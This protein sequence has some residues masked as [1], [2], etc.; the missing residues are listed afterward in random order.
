MAGMKQLPKLAEA[1]ALFFRQTPEQR[2]ATAQ[3]RAALPVDQ[4]GLGLPADNT[5]AQ[6][7]DVMFPETVYRGMQNPRLDNPNEVRNLDP[8]YNPE[9]NPVVVADNKPDR[10]TFVTPSEDLARTY[11]KH[12][13][14]LR[15]DPSDL[16]TIDFDGRYYT[17][18]SWDPDNLDEVPHDI[19]NLLEG[20]Y[21]AE[22]VD[23]MVRTGERFGLTKDQV[24]NSTLEFNDFADD[25][26][27]FDLDGN[28]I[29]TYK[30]SGTNQIAAD[31]NS[32]DFDGVVF[33]NIFDIGHAGQSGEVPF[34]VLDSIEAPKSVYALR[35][36]R[37]RHSEAGFDPFLKDWKHM[38]AGAAG[39]GILL[40]QIPYDEQKQGVLARD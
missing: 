6:R 36:N 33:N 5:A 28:L 8:R 30:K 37:I 32:S 16:P 26:D 35:D 39:T 13:Y 27:M 12:V 14:E 29:K 18:T 11:G 10:L 3:Q 22:S 31:I 9:P 2:M 34:N 7:A 40:D 23:D 17:G 4:G 20:D 21:L 15:V 1:I 24:M 38:L 19:F 25:L